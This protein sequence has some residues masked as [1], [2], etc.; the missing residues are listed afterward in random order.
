MAWAF[1]APY[2]APFG[3]TVQRE[4][5]FVAHVGIFAVAALGF[6][7][8]FPH[9]QRWVTA[10]LLVAAVGLEAAQLVL[11]TR[12]ADVA[13]FAMNCVGI[14]LGLLV[15]RAGAVLCARVHQKSNQT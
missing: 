1:L 5:G 11:P 10:T 15:F 9:A 13:D 2:P 3:I 14:F 12:G 4:M 8:A 7:A 6:L